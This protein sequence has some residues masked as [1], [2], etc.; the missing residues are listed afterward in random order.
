MWAVLDSNRDVGQCQTV[1]GTCGT[2][3]SSNKDM[4][5]SAGQ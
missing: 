2:V 4:W 5:D 3:P 1:I